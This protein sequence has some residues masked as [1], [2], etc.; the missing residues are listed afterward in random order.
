M[1]KEIKG[2]LA[3]YINNSCSAEELTKV[4][5]ILQSGLYEQ[6][7]QAVMEE[8]EEENNNAADQV[9]TAIYPFQPGKVWEGITAAT[10][11]KQKKYPYQWPIAIAATLLISLATAYLTYNHKISAPK[12]L[13]MAVQLT[14]VREKKIITL[15]DGSRI[16]LNQRSEIRYSA[17]FEGDK[18]EVFL[19]GE[20]FFDVKHD[21]KRPFI[22]HTDKLNVQ[23]LGTSFNVKSYRTDARTS[24]GV[25]T[26]KVGVNSVKR[27]A[28]YMLLPGDL[29]SCNKEDAAFN[30]TRLDINEIAAWQNGILAFH[31][32]ALSDIVPELERWFDV[33]VNVK[34]DALLKKRIT[35]SFSGKSLVAVLEILSKT[36][37][38]TYSINKNEVYIN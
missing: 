31:Q 10:S 2:L 32:E 27:A 29:L 38:F 19:S 28:T 8:E 6:E 34:R 35:A 18:R 15:S 20:A 17:A 14:G 37:G 16:F 12:E 21:V 26:G 22:V 11:A 4:K 13:V 24:V 33:K 23:V 7:W 5:Y 3:K 1:N 36:A 25:V 9:E 30:Q